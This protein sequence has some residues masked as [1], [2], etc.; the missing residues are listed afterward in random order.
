MR[1][2]WVLLAAVIGCGGASRDID[3]FECSE[4]S[5][6]GY[7]PACSAPT[8]ELAV[9]DS[10]TAEVVRAELAIDSEPAAEGIN[11]VSEGEHVLAV[12]VQLAP[13][14]TREE[15]AIATAERRVSVAAGCMLRVQIATEPSVA[16]LPPA[17]RFFETLRCENALHAEASIPDPRELSGLP[18]PIGLAPLERWGAECIDNA[19]AADRYVALAVGAALDVQDLVVVQCLAAKLD[20]IA[21]LRDA[22]EGNST[23]APASAA[24]LERDATLVRSVCLRVLDLQAEAKQCI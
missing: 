9:D 11:I 10:A 12:E 3:T 19:Q 4:G 17:I 7:A 20:R 14:E 22:I 18:Q 21:T 2:S 6:L 23:F 15:G 16:D 1:V 13:S 8:L 24:E 5:G